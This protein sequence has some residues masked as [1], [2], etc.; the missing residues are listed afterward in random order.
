MLRLRRSFTVCL[1]TAAVLTLGAGCAASE[2]AASEGATTLPH[3]LA[4]S[5]Y[6]ASLGTPIDAYIANPPS[7][8]ARSI[9]L[10]FEGTFT[11]PD[12]RSE[13]VSFTQ[14]TN[15]LEAGAVRWTTFGPFNNPFTPQMP[16][17]G[18]FMGKAGV[19]VTMADGSTTMDENP[20]PMTFEVKPSIVL[21]ELQPTTAECGKPALRLIGAM[22]YKMKAM[23]VGFNPT[24]IEYAF[25]TPGV[26]PDASGRPVIQTQE[27]GNALYQTTRL[28]HAMTSNVDE[29][30]EDEALVLPPV[31]VDVPGY[32][33]VFAITARDAEGRKVSTTFGM[34]AHNPI[35]VF[36][37][38]RFDLAQIYPATPVS[39]C[40]PGGQQGRS[41]DYSEAQTETRQRQLSVTLSKSWLKSEENNW[42]TSDGKTVTTSTTNTDSWSNSKSTS[43]SFSFTRSRSDTTGVSFNWS[44]S[45][46]TVKG[47]NAK[48]EGKVSFGLFGTGAEV[49]GGGGYHSDKTTN[50]TR[51]GERSS[52]STTGWSQGTTNTETDT[53]TTGGSTATT[54]STAVTTTNTKGGSESESEGTGE[55]ETDSWTVSSSQTIQRG[56]SASVI[57]GT[58]GVFYR[59]M[60]RYTRRAFVMVYDKCGEGDVVGDLTLQDYVWAPDLALS[61]QCP[62]LPTSNFP[63]PQCYFPPCDP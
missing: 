44:D 42:S 51:G 34:T 10:V 38:G 23:A 45:K 32:G 39:S 4:L 12:G 49:G 61:E 9:E 52:S 18:T 21:T 35:E 11:H 57:A 2:D 47:W 6:S 27:D 19:R 3:L 17:V 5:T 37:D 24:S 41:V 59:Q 1:A 50:S 20:I 62:P 48:G 63:A 56:F 14:R 25:Q 16:D 13:P 26:V 33:V 58:Y 8:D 30:G 54:D 31:P 28:A 43:N 36:Y 7:A 53:S 29:I 15:R 60:A 55:A 46:G 22:A 40:I